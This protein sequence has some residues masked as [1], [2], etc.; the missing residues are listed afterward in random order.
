MPAAKSLAAGGEINWAQFFEKDVN[1]ETVRELV[2]EF[3][4]NKNFEE[5]IHCIEQAILS[6]QIQPWMHQV[7]AVMMQAAGRP[8]AQIERVLLSSQDFID[9]DPVSMMA[10]AANL[11]QF[12][13]IDRALELYRQAAALD[14]SR[15]EPYVLGLELAARTRNYKAVVWS[16]PEVLSFSWSKSRRE[17]NRLAESSATEAETALIASGD[18]A[19]AYQLRAA[20]QQARKLDLIIRVE[21]NGD[22]DIDLEVV[23][24]TGKSCSSVHPM[25]AAGGVFLHDGFGPNQ[26]N[27]YEEYICPQGLPGDYQIVIRHMSGNIVGKRAQVTLTRYRGTTNE[28]SITETIFL[29]PTDQRIRFSLRGGRRREANAEQQ[30]IDAKT[31]SKPKAAGRSAVLAQLS[32]PVTG[33][34]AI[35][36]NNAVGFTPLI[37]TVNEGVQMGAMAIVSGDRRYVRI[38]ATPMFSTITDVFSFTFSR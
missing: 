18:V 1:P 30:S 15:P 38:Q 10:L 22:G 19:E 7:L 34:Q 8:N 21:W 37:T 26:E 32:N 9:S 12:D 20:M 27:C 4:R 11:V 33:G 16:A 36:G 6:G 35:A 28:E 2:L 14:P 17:L 23:D 3:A 29:G 13:R 31:G 24:P 5:G 25:T